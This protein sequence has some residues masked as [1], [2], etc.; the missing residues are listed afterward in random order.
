MEIHT[1]G[2]N[3][4]ELQPGRKEGPELE[5]LW[6]GLNPFKIVSITIIG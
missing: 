5:Q 6:Q 2:W 4:E 3:S 1:L